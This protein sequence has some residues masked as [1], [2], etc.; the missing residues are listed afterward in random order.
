MYMRDPS[1][2]LYFISF[3]VR[4]FSRT[5]TK[6]SVFT[7]SLTHTSSIIIIG[8]GG[9]VVFHIRL[10]ILLGMMTRKTQGY[11][12]GVEQDRTWKLDERRYLPSHDGGGGRYARSREVQ[13]YGCESEYTGEHGVQSTIAKWISGR[14]PMATHFLLHIIWSVFIILRVLRERCLLRCP[15]FLP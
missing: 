9:C 7:S 15:L 11:G 10:N 14:V 12:S 5:T 13:S 4:F 1:S 8:L 3:F 6:N 2:A